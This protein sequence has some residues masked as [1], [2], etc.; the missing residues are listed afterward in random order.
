MYRSE[1]A[2][3]GEGGQAV[4]ASIDF[5]A[6]PR[7]AA[8]R[9]LGGRETQQDDL[10]CFH[11]ASEDVHLLVLADGM[12]GDGAGELASEG[13]VHIA[14]RLWESRL[15]QEQPSSLFLES[16]CQ[17]AHEELRR[18]RMGL[19][20]GEPHSTVVAILVRGGQVSWV[21]VG[22]SR[23]YRFRRGR[24]IG[25]TEDH[26]VAQLKRQRGELTERELANDPDQHKLLRGL[27]GSEAPVVEHGCALLRA[28]QTFVMC[29]DGVWEQLTTEELGRLSSRRDQHDALREA[30]AL[31]VERGGMHG[32]NVALIFAR[33]GPDGW[34]RRWCDGFW[35]VVRRAVATRRR[36]GEHAATLRNEV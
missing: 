5:Q 34:I 23:L 16:L 25:R 29:S 22:D 26:S 6:I 3:K 32:D 20:D 4:D 17:Q 33:L 21:H 36:T 27:G 24:L 31:A 30:L 11:D 2:L 13:V 12:G 8:G 10:V 28:D 18:R 1:G 15:W 14:R 35:S 9:S 19:A 7:V